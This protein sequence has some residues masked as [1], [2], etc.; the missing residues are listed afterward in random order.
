M[1]QELD[2]KI[3]QAKVLLSKCFIAEANFASFL[4]DCTEKHGTGFTLEETFRAKELARR[5]TDLLDQIK[6]EQDTPPDKLPVYPRGSPPRL[7]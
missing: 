3:A 7:S 4:F 6:S 2:Q 1:V 5:I